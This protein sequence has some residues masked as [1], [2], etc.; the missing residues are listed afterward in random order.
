MNKKKILIVAKSLSEGGAERAAAILSIMLKDFNYDVSIIILDNKVSYDFYGNYFILN[1]E[2]LKK[3]FKTRLGF[4]IDFRN[5]VKKN[6]FNYI[7]DFRTRNSSL[8]EILIYR[9]IYKKVK[10]I[11]FTIHLPK[12]F[13][14][15]PRP[16]FL[17]KKVYSKA[18]KNIV[19]SQEIKTLLKEKLS[20]NNTDLIYNAI[21]INLINKL[22]NE[23]ILEKDKFILIVGRMNDDIKQIDKLINIYTE[24]NLKERNIKLFIMGSGVL[25]KDIIDSVKSRGLNNDIHFLSFQENPYKYMSKAMF[26]VLCS[27]MEGFPYVILESLACGNPVITFD[28]RTGPREVI[29]NEYNG[30]LVEDQNFLELKN[31]INKFLADSKLYDFC[32]SNTLKS[33]EKYDIKIIAEDWIH[34][35][36]LAN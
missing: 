29:V 34:V 12:L 9:F 15:V 8:R 17:F 7:I 14:Y 36:E 25:T 33:V 18:L 3:N 23:D 10:N 16:Y 31:A 30:L 27:K 26:L 6:N 32:K 21:D 13:L 5:Y 11:I 2:K 28:C 1:K 20:L 4:F 24:T 22:K 35:L 19:V